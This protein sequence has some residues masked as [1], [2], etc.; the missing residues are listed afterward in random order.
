MTTMTRPGA[1]GTGAPPPAAPSAETA[2]RSTWRSSWAVAL[3]MARR[4]VWRHRG[5]SLVVLLMVG[6]PTALLTFGL[7]LYPTS[8]VSGTERIPRE[9]GS[10]VASVLSPVP[11]Q[12]AQDVEGQNAAYVEDAAKPIPGYAADAPVAE[13]TAALSAFFKGTAVPIRDVECR[14]RVGDV[15]KRLQVAVVDG[16]AGLGDVARLVSGRW[17]SNPAEVTVT[18]AGVQQ[19]GLPTSGTLEV[20]TPTGP[21]TA[22]VVGVSEVWKEWG[23]IQG[24]V[25]LT[26]FGASSYNQTKWIIKRDTPMTWPEVRAANEHGL[27]VLS[28]DALRHPPADSELDPMVREGIHNANSTAATLG[29]AGGS[30]LLIVITLLVGPA[31]A[32]S[33]A[34]QRRTL[35]LAASNGA[36]TAQLRHTVLAQAVVLGIAASALGAVIGVAAVVVTTNLVIP[37]FTVWTGGPLDVPWLQILGVTAV[38]MLSAVIAALLPARRLGRLDIVGV[39]KGQSVSPPLSRS[40]PIAG[41]IAAGVGGFALFT[42]VIGRRNEVFVV[43]GAIL[44]IVG[45]LCLVPML[46]VLAARFAS[47]LPV[48]LRMATRDAARQRTRSGPSV[49]AVVAALAA[50]TMML[51]GLSSD[52]EQQRREYRPSNIAGEATL[53]APFDDP[54]A[55]T[56]FSDTVKGVDDSLVLTPVLI[57][58]GNTK[59][60]SGER[61]PW[62]NAVPQGCTA[63]EIVVG[64]EPWSDTPKCAILGTQTMRNHAGIGALALEEIARR[65]D[66]SADE[67]ATL[68]AGGA[69]EVSANPL[70]GDSLVVAHGTVGQDA[71]T[72]NYSEVVTTGQST[73][74]LVHRTL[75][76]D[77]LERAP[78]DLGLLVT[79]ETAQRLGW[80]LSTSQLLVH[81]PNGPITRDT[82]DRINTALAAEEGNFQVERGF[83]RGDALIMAI[84]VGVFA[85]LVL[86]ITLTSTALSLAEQQKDDATLAALGAT[87]ATRRG[88]AAAQAFVIGAIGSLIGVAV[89]MVPGI[90]IT[91]PLTGQVPCDPITGMCSGDYAAPTILIPW[92][93]LA[94]AAVGVPVLA[95]LIAAVSVRR[96]PV[97]IRRAT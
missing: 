24:I 59:A 54:T 95:A 42:A 38:A 35:A 92:L 39:M 75:T 16:R 64:R 49:A 76:T 18:S 27:L 28:A 66:L 77:L 94:V 78:A 65:F 36:T 67:R 29:V 21:T 80:S 4:D 12:V 33:A 1:A 97:M 46:L 69:L 50:L 73:L 89:G 61:Q 53:Y 96:A 26:D 32:V 56:R 2:G 40:L 9:I 19:R 63:E 13:A 86:V 91:Y 5:R 7:T 17:P 68:Q 15:N 57:P 84:L 48:S 81:S 72:G 82:E 37:H 43:A 34:R 3:R 47:R 10:G 25:A 83:Q 79:P 44:L 90:A 51:I 41:A 52:T 31:F 45:A 30:I 58:S 74:R 85:F 14:V 20:S 22:T 62:I 23:P 87:R 11:N 8:V 71:S 60:P 93:W 70:K 88:M 55:L 6:L